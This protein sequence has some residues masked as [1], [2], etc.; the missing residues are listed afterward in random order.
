MSNW[1]FPRW[2]YGYTQV[3]GYNYFGSGVPYDVERRDGPPAFGVPYPA[4]GWACTT[5]SNYINATQQ[6]CIQ[7]ADERMEKTGVNCFAE[8]HEIEKPIKA[9]VKNTIQTLKS[10]EEK[11]TSWN[12]TALKAVL[13]CFNQTQQR[14]ISFEWKQVSESGQPHEK[15]YVYELTCGEIQTKGTDRTKKGAKIK[16]AEEMAPRLQAIPIEKGIQKKG[17]SFNQLCPS[18]ARR[19]G[20]FGRGRGYHRRKWSRE[21]TE[22]YILKLN[23]KTSKPDQLISSD[24]NPVCQ[25]YDHFKR[26]KWP[27]PVFNCVSEQIVDE[28]INNKGNRI[29]K[30]QFTTEC[31]IQILGE[32]KTFVGNGYTKKHAKAAAAQ[33]VW[34]H[35]IQNQA[36]LN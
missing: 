35:I 3:P 12:K 1:R 10:N 20:H 19:G 14:G 29:K 33:A 36:T 30:R 5:S 22:D 13:Y 16:A 21:S 17:F 31:R 25:V 34:D 8:D 15:V 23:D 7:T 4:E 6:S 27:E 28:W 18:V 9:A 11:K 24:K 26:K 2:K 32:D